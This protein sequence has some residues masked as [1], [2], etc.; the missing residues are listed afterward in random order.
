[1]AAGMNNQF[2]ENPILNSP[3]TY[4]RRHWELD[5]DGQPTQKI[6]E[7]RRRAEFISPIPKSK[8]RGGKA[9][10]ELQVFDDG[11]GDHDLL[12][13]V[14]EVKGYRGEDAKDKKPTMETLWVPGVNR[15]GA[16]GRWAFAELRDVYTMR[17]GFE[18]RSGL[19]NE[20]EHV[21]GEFL[22]EIRAEA[23]QSLIRAGGSMPDLEY[24][25]RRR[26][27]MPG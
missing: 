22:E 6:V 18:L 16:Y 12:H 2:F 17:E 4:P 15:L 13:L 10:Q 1:M 7:R 9:E 19:H 11:H 23:A 24:I 3:Y 27:P 21:A 8:K 26:S 20:F 5:G 14:I 25:P